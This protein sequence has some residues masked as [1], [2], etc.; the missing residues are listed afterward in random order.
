MIFLRDSGEHERIQ[1]RFEI[2][3]KLIEG[4]VAEVIEVPAQGNG[5]IARLL[6]LILVTQLAAI[7]V[8]LGYEVDPGPVESIQKLKNELSKR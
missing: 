3:R 7:Y 1:L 2:T 6:S 5:V 8:G 4:N